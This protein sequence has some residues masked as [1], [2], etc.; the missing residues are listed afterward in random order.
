VTTPDFS[1]RIG[2]LV[3][4]RSVRVCVLAAVAAGFAFGA[5]L[6]PPFPQSIAY[7]EFADA[8]RILGIPNFWD[9]LTNLPFLLVGVAGLAFLL[10]D[11]RAQVAFQDSAERWPYAAF[12]LGVAMTSAGS[13]FYHLAPD[14][15]RLV[16]DRLPMTVGFMS[17]VAAMVAERLDVK[18][19]LRL[20][21]PLLALG[22]ASVV[23]WRLSASWDVENL[24]PYMAVQYGSI[25]VVL[26]IAVLFPSRYTRGNDIYVVVALYVA[27]KVAESLDTVIFSFE[28]ILSGHSLKHL[29]AACALYQILRML[30]ARTLNVKEASS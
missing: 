6:L 21:V 10:R 11:P 20:L 19:G 14:N 25:A 15:A 3:L 26:L 18:A 12:F 13:A 23:W 27:A 17:I 30:K 9:V 28:S 24:R 8:R 22:V 29:I 4:P 5:F 2:G 1:S 16:W 7:H